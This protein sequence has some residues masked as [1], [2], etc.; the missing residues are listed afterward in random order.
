M[1][2]L[3]A[4]KQE[5]QE[6]LLGLG[7]DLMGNLDIKYA[8]YFDDEV[9]ELWEAQILEFVD[10]YED[11]YQQKV[12]D[13]ELLNAKKDEMVCKHSKKKLVSV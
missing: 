12:Q 8:P 6:T 2:K 13:E 7:N 3:L 4:L 9:K 11:E 5:R 1:S 10:F